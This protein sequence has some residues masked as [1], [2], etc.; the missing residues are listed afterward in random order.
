M[1]EKNLLEEEILQE[2]ELDKD[3]TFEVSKDIKITAR[4]TFKKGDI[5]GQLVNRIKRLE[6]EVEK[7]NKEKI[8]IIEDSL[9][10]LW[11]NEEDARWDK[12]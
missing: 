6:N 5:I 9:K 10:E 8:F 7:L 2:T 1:N 11:E 12:C 4:L 3:I